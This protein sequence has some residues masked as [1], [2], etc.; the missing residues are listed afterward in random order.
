MHRDA[1]GVRQGGTRVLASEGEQSQLA[2]QLTRLGGD[3]GLVGISSAQPEE[4]LRAGIYHPPQKPDAETF[5][6]FS[7]GG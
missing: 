5:S 7:L 1:T 6:P 2:C 4:P 3:A